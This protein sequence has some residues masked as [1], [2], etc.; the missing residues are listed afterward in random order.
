MRRRTKKSARRSD[1]PSLRCSQTYNSTLELVFW[2][3]FAQG[4][5]KTVL[6]GTIDTIDVSIVSMPVLHVCALNRM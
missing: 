1:A 6:D 2:K 5:G 3:P 4:R